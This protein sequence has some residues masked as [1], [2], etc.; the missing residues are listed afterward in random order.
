M[1]LC[2]FLLIKQMC[3]HVDRK[4]ISNSTT[5]FRP[6]LSFFPA[7]LFVPTFSSLA[8][9]INPSSIQETTEYAKISVTSTSI[10]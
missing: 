4:K 8:L 10:Q 9:S 1:T 5:A 7:L 2:H 3:M 6:F